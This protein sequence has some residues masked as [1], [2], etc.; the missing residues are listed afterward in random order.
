[1][2][3]V[4]ALLCFPLVMVGLLLILFGATLVSLSQAI[5]DFLTGK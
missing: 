2:K 1:M 3:S 5:F 4:V